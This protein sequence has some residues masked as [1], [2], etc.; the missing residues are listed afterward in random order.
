[1]ATGRLLLCAEMLG[2]IQRNRTSHVPMRQS[3]TSTS[4]STQD[5]VIRKIFKVTGALPC[6]WVAAYNRQLLRVVFARGSGTSHLRC[7]VFIGASAQSRRS[8]RA[9]CDLSSL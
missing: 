1:M 8:G 9:A 2:A 4:Q 6:V 5:E 3:K 7:P